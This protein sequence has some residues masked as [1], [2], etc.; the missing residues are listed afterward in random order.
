MIVD[1][2]DG[3]EGETGGGLVRRLNWQRII[4]QGGGGTVIAGDFDSHS[5][6]WDPTCTEQW[7][8]TCL[9]AI[10]GE[11]WL[12]FGNDN[13]R[14]DYWNQHNS[15]G[16][17]VIDL[18]LANRSVGKW[19]ILDMSHASGSNREIIAWELEMEKQ[20]E[21]RGTEIVGR[22]LAGVSLK[23][24]EAFEK[25]WGERAKERS[26]LGAE[27]TGDKVESEAKWC[28]EALSNVLDAIAQ[29]LTICAHS[30]RWWNGE[31][32]E[33]RSQL[34]RQKRRRS[35]WAVTGRAKAELQKSVRRA[36][37]MMWNDN[38]YNLTA[39]EV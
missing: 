29:K 6:P 1:I 2:H 32:K 15:M 8:T 13:S 16:E 28:E 35:R 11:H 12:V 38:L 3:R 23:D 18:T 4:G 22:N 31:I 25:L 9:E 20:E 27:R 26:H 14:S 21:G 7:D 19:M 36:K 17:S 24:F 34:G 5:Q 33:K 10:I 37:G 39:A 30:K